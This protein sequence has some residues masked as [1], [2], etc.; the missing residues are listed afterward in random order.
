MPAGVAIRPRRPEGP[1]EAQV[2]AFGD[3]WRDPG[4]ER[5]PRMMRDVLTPRFDG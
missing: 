2:V 5:N 1:E 4:C 3:S